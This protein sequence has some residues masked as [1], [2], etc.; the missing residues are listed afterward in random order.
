MDSNTLCGI[1]EKV[2]GHKRLSDTVL[3]CE[4]KDI[5]N[6]ASLLALANAI[7]EHVM[8]ETINTLVKQTENAQRIS[9]EIGRKAQFDIDCAALCECCA[10]KWDEDLSESH[11]DRR[12]LYNAAGALVP[13]WCHCMEALPDSVALSLPSIAT[14]Q[15][16]I[17]RE[18]KWQAE[19]DDIQ[20]T[21]V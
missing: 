1:I 8:D 19:H 3:D 6:P 12:E 2:L 21:T 11:V 15:A 17:L 18:V 20:A 13:V 16:S 7:E 5:V 4:T 14:C 9:F 10:G